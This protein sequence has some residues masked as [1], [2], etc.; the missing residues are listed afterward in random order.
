MEAAKL[1]GIRY[2]AGRGCNTLPRDEG[3][4]IPDEMRETTKVFIDDCERLLKT[5]HNKAGGMTG[6]VVAPCQPVNCYEDTFIE[7]V[8][9]AR[10]YG[11]GL[12][13]HLS[14]GEN[15]A[16][17]ARWGERTLEWAEK[18]GFFGPDV[19]YAH[20][21]ELTP[22]ELTRMGKV[23]TGVAHCPTPAALCGAPILDISA[24]TAKGVPVSLGCDGSATNDSSNLLDAL[25]LAYMLQCLHSH[26]R[27]G[28]IPSPYEL[29]K[30]ATVTGAKTLGRP[31]LGSLAV[32]QG[33]DLFL[34]DVGRIEFA[35]T[36]H[37]PK[38]LLPRCGVTGPTALTMV[39]GNV[40][41]RNNEFPG[42]DEA[43]L[44]AAAETH[45]TKLLR[46]EFP[47]TYF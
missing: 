18:R 30:A 42:L 8:A 13:T 37:D 4:T 29:L 26:E 19:W 16:M 22:A 6:I 7:A 1:L 23:G 14:E 46:D 36:L 47:T 34:V 38:N 11:A 21:W 10:Q 31:D 33:A 3:S 32:G 5:Y 44:Y 2:Y 15:D 45:C 20:G 25:R 27:K 9:L 28:V 12:H 43:A 40:V 17:V 24:M 35:G 41:W 39:A